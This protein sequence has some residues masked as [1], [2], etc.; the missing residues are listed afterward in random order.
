MTTIR[1]TLGP[2]GQKFCVYLHKRPDGSVFYIGKG[3]YYRAHDFSQRRRTLHH[4]NVTAKHGIANIVVE[5]QWCESEESAFGLERELIAKHRLAGMALVNLTDGGEGAS[6]RR[7]TPEQLAAH[8]EAVKRGWDARGRKERIGPPLL[9]KECPQC[10]N[11]FETMNPRKK[12]CDDNCS[13]RY[14][15]AKIEKKPPAMYK[16]NTSGRVGVY[17]TASGKWL[18]MICVQKKLICLGTHATKEAAIAARMQAEKDNGRA[19]E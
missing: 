13:Q 4:R 14:A 17:A 18:A 7:F 9:G 6:G 1:S 19:Y 2:S 8:S 10:L 12:F 16:S 5:V 15:R 11:K 3:T